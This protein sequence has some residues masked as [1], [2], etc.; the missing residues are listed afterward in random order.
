MVR[1]STFLRSGKGKAR[2][3]V[4]RPPGR[5]R[6]IHRGLLRWAHRLPPLAR[7]GELRHAGLE[8]VDSMKEVRKLCTVELLLGLPLDEPD[9]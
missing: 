1:L 2:D 8:S 6:S 9:G 4:E 3:E 7:A 5:T